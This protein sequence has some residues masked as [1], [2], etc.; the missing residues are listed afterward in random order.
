MYCIVLCILYIQYTYMYTMYD[1]RRQ[2]RDKI[3]GL[4]NELE[5]CRRRLEAPEAFQRPRRAEV[6]ARQQ[7]EKAYT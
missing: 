3:F 1:P 6:D 2:L 5:L 4:E 7:L